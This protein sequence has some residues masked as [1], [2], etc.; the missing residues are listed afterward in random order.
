MRMYRLGTVVVL[1]AIVAGCAGFEHVDTAPDGKPMSFPGIRDYLQK[2]PALHVLQTHGMGDHPAEAFC[3]KGG[4][5]LQ[6]QDRIAGK[7]GYR[8]TPDTADA[9][10]VPIDRDGVRVGSYSTRLY[11][12]DLQVPTRQLYFSCLTWGDASRE[13]KRQM[14]ELDADFLEKNQNERHRARINRAAKRFVNRSF[15]DPVIYVGDF[16]PF[17]RD[18]VREGIFRIGQAQSGNRASLVR[19]YPALQPAPAA[20]SAYGFLTETPMLVITDSLGSRVLFDVLWPQPEIAEESRQA[21]VGSLTHRPT[22]DQLADV[23]KQVRG[24]YLLANQLP[25]LSLAEV[26]PPPQGVPLSDWLKRKSCL[27]PPEVAALKAQADSDEPRMTLVAFSD[28]NDALSYRL[29]DDFKSRCAPPGSGLLVVNVTLT[30]ARPWFGLYADLMKAHAD[31]FKD[32]G[33]AIGYL[34]EGN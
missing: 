7:L 27:L 11:V 8:I 24:I 20:P 33:D 10:T 12:D 29:S 16:G 34:V 28:V 30:N 9:K 5:N 26:K 25:L 32:N 17:I 31:G 23:R 19:R 13:I 22:P 6:M 4:P 14:L 2:H 21:S 15:S 3:A 18:I 1:A